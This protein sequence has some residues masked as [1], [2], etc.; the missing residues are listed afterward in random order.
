MNISEN[1]HPS[2][3]ISNFIYFTYYFINEIRN[4]L[5]FDLFLQIYNFVF[6]L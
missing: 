3:N 5:H 2:K 4:S 6:F 1:I